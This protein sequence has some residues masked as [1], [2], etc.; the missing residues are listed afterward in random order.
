MQVHVIE[1]SLQ[2]S[3]VMHCGQAT[4]AI[5]TMIGGG[6]TGARIEHEIAIQGLAWIAGSWLSRFIGSCL[7]GGFVGR[8]AR[9]GSVGAH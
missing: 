8:C 6:L 5:G 9:L 4:L 3:W 2:Y 7:V 1:A